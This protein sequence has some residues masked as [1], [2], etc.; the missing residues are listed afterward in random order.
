VT[1]FGR[2]S[3]APSSIAQRG[4]G[5]YHTAYSNI[6][7]PRNR[8]K[9]LTLGSNQAITPR[10]TNEL[11][12]N[13]SES[14][15]ESF[16]TLD[17][18]EGAVSPLD[19][20]LFPSF[21]S[22]NNGFFALFGDFTP[23]GL[24]FN[25]GKIA[26]NLQH[27][28]NVTDGVSRVIGTHQLK[29]GLDYRRL[30]PEEGALTYQLEYV[31]GSVQAFLDNS[32]P[33]AFI[34]SR[35]ADVQLVIS[36]WSLFAQDTWNIT[37]SVTITYGVRWE[38][39]AAPSSPNG[40]LPFTVTQADNLATMAL[41]PSG[42]PLWHPQK[43]DF[44]PRLGLAWHPRQNL[45]VRA[46]AGIFYDLG[47]ADIT[48][49]MTAFPYA[50]GKFIFG[51]SFPLSDTDAMPPP[52]TTAPPSSYSAVVDPNHVLPR[53]YEWNAA[54]EQTLGK[55]DVLT[56]T[57]LGAGGRKPASGNQLAGFGVS[58]FHREPRRRSHGRR[59]TLPSGR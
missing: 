4:G 31:F 50:Q 53:T 44:A 52:F 7:H 28:I 56:L 47:Y 59:Q 45:V 39:N 41:A 30:R 34:G 42:T 2:Y 19:S 11:R 29:F 46:G 12:F 35:T 38:Y 9:S 17:D 36:N 20:T 54:V 10:L 21:A 23:F 48:S 16:L 24:K 1:V 57:Y 37:P 8:S 3:D 40:T 15:G 32:V 6:F 49:A 51:T 58:T 26:D 18:F 55:S 27:Q 22:A 33:E 14:R 43:H 25:V 5:I 13:Y